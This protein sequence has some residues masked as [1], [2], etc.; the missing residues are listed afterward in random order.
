MPFE[1]VKVKKMLLLRKIHEK[2]KGFI[3]FWGMSKMGEGME[4]WSQHLRSF[5][6]V[7]C[8]GFYLCHFQSVEQC[9]KES[10]MHFTQCLREEIVTQESTTQAQLGLNLRSS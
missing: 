4:R 5:V 7:K 1:K 6:S 3:R 9:F 10:M 8:K 2:K